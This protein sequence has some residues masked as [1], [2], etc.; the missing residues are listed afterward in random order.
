MVAA[1][2]LFLLVALAI[3]ATGGGWVALGRVD[4]ALVLPG[5]ALATLAA[6]A[7]APRLTVA[8]HLRR[9]AGFA[10]VLLLGL[11][12]AIMVQFGIG[13]DWV[14]WG[15]TAVLALPTA[16]LWLA[17]GVGLM[18]WAGAGRGWRRLAAPIA[19]LCAIIMW[20][21]VAWRLLALAYDRAGMAAAPSTHRSDRDPMVAIITSLPNDRAAQLAL[22]SQDAGHAGHSGDGPLVIIDGFGPRA[23]LHDSVSAAIAS[24]PDVLVL[25]HPA[26]LSPQ[27][28]VA[29]DTAVRQGT[30]ALI[31]A[32]GFSS[33][34]APHPLGDPRN[35]PITSLLTP[36]LLHWGLELDAP[37][38]LAAAQ[39]PL[40]DNGERLTLH[41][42]GT[43]TSHDGACRIDAGG[44]IARCPIGRGMVTIMADAD[45]LDARHWSGPR[46]SLSAV[47]WSAGNML[48]LRAELARLA[49]Q[50][51]DGR[52]T[53]ALFRPLWVAQ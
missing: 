36:L 10:L 22:P 25:A 52:R 7:A 34:P 40:L 41:S 20:Q 39:Q 32:D 14:Q 29:I 47:G 5:L 2:I 13:S 15:C 46:Q 30:A 26:A 49:R 44:V 8:E 9:W 21:G 53:G 51:P 18:N 27:D 12:A 4:P 28:L 31:L 11:L 45:W 19:A 37:D 23:T 33:W 50:S 43:L 3:G 24:A 1:I 16:V 6:M 42:A 35:P 38:G 48:W 17:I